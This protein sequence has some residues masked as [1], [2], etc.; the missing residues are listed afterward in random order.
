[1]KKI[2]KHSSLRERSD[3]N[4][5]N[6]KET[7]NSTILGKLL[8]QTQ[9]NTHAYLKMTHLLS[10]ICAFKPHRCQT[11]RWA[12]MHKQTHIHTCSCATQRKEEGRREEGGERVTYPQKS[13]PIRRTDIELRS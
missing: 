2:Q 8:C 12:Q 3:K 10:L 5:E 6:C 7:N 11:D 1:M 13:R 4:I 9:K